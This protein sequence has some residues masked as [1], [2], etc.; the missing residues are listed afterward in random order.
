[1]IGFLSRR[2]VAL[3]PTLLGMTVMLFLISSILPVDPARAALG[4]DATME[5]VEAYRKQ[6][7]L[8]QPLWVQ[9]FRYVSNVMRGDLGN[10]IVSRRPVVEDL[11]EK[12]AATLELSIVSI[13]IS[14][15]IAIPLGIASAVSRN[16]LTD[17][18]SRVVSLFSVSMPIFWLAMMMQLLFYAKLGWL[19]YGGRLDPH[20]A[21]PP[22]VTGFYTIDSLIAG[23]FTTFLSAVKH[24][25]LPAV[26]L[27]NI[28]SGTLARITRSSMLD[29]LTETYIVTARA[30]GLRERSVICFHALKNAAIPIVTLG[31]MQFGHLIG[32]AVLTETI[33]AWPGIGRYAA[34]SIF[35]SDLPAVMGFALLV[36]LLFAL[37]N[38][39]VDVLYGWLDPR[40]R[41]W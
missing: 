12:L 6:L 36:T 29:V 19:P 25:F 35:W 9:F 40:I 37:V 27:S 18:V 20:I 13:V 7:G 21:A 31:G 15:L 14:S 3:I 38:L 26:A 22:Q 5:Q 2:L 39:G 16:S 11:K 41:S 4:E 8:D 32:G 17:H 30:K 23:D 33:F 28:S 34:Y 24:L 10:S 1:M